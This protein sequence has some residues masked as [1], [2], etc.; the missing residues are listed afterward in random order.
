MARGEDSEEYQRQIEAHRY[1]LTPAY[2]AQL[3]Q[4]FFDEKIPR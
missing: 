3:K 1:L 2:Y 4:D